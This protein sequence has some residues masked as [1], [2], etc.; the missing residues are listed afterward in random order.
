MIK[1]RDQFVSR[2]DLVVKDK[3]KSGD[4]AKLTNLKGKSHYDILRERFFFQ[5]IV[6]WF[7]EIYSNERNKNRNKN[8]TL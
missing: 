3:I 6:N 5:H 7:Y 2:M 8:I 1:F 4:I